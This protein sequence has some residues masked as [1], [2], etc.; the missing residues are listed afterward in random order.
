MFIMDANEGYGEAGASLGWGEFHAWGQKSSAAEPDSRAAADGRHTPELGDSWP[1]GVTAVPVPN[2]RAQPDALQFELHE[3]ARDVPPRGFCIDLVHQ[4]CSHTAPL[5][6]RCIHLCTPRCYTA[7]A[8]ANPP[9][10]NT[11]CAGV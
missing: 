6:V 3:G 5:E 11:T 10:S 8:G 2:A 7:A 9:S 4:V 1:A